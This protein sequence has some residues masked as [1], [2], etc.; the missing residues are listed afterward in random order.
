MQ[1]NFRRK[2]KP[3][4]YI[5]KLF[6]DMSNGKLPIKYFPLFESPYTLEYKVDWPEK[7]LALLIQC[8]NDLTSALTRIG[9]LHDNLDKEEARKEL[10]NNDEL[11]IWNVFI[12][13]FSEFEVD[14][15]MIGDLYFRRETD[16]LDEE[17]DELLERHYEW[18]V[19]NSIE[20]LPHIKRNP[21]HY[22]N[23]VQK[24]EALIQQNAPE[25]VLNEEGC[26]LAEEMVLYYFGLE[27]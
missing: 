10:L 11:D 19:K 4:D 2:I 26:Y 22:I 9:K 1:E 27:D 8:Y 20:R 12:R 7:D 5:R 21:A 23:R 13:P 17:E 3:Q 15:S 6:S 24:Y 25:T 14:L 18:F 16:S